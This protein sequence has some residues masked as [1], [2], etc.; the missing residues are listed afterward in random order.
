MMLKT[1]C[2]GAA[3][4][5]VILS[6]CSS[7]SSSD[8]KPRIASI[9][10]VAEP[11]ADNDQI[12]VAFVRNVVEASV[13]LAGNWTVES[14]IGTAFDLTGA[15]ID[16]DPVTYTA[17]V[18]LGAGTVGGPFGNNLQFGDSLSVE[19]TGV[20]GTNGAPLSA[21][22]Q[23]AVTG[24]D[25]P[26]RTL[27]VY[28]DGVT[29]T[30]T[31]R[32]SEAAREVLFANL[33]NGMPGDAGPR[34]RLTDADGTPGT[35][36]T[37]QVQLTGQPLDGDFV[38][39][40]DG[41]VSVDF[42]FDS[43]ASVVET[44]TLRQ[45]V[46][47]P[48]AADTATNLFNAVNSG[49]YTFDVTATLAVLDVNL[50][51]DATGVAGNVA[52]NGNGST[53][54]TVTGMTGGVDD[55]ATIEEPLGPG[56]GWSLDEEGVTVD[57]TPNVPNPATDTIEIY[58][59][60]DLA[61]NAAFPEAAFALEAEDVS[62]PALDT[63]SSTLNVVSGE[64]NDTI[65]ARFDSDMSATHIT[66]PGNYSAGALDLSGAD[67]A[68]D[69]SDTLT[70]TLPEGQDIQVG[71]SYN[72]T[73]VANMATPLTTAQGVPLAL[74]E[75]EAVTAT[76]DT[77]AIIQA[78]TSGYVGDLGNPSTAVVV[79]P[80]AVDVAGATA[81]ANYDILAANPTAIE[82]L[83]P[84]SMRLT[85]ASAPA[86]TDTLNIQPAAAT[87]RGGTPAAGV[88]SIVLGAADATAPTAT[89]S[90]TSVAGRGGDSI[91]I[92]FD[93][94]VRM[95]QALD[96]DSYAVTEDLQPVDLTGATLSYES[97]GDVVRIDL[98]AGTELTTGSTVAVTLTGV[99]DLSGN[100]LSAQPAG[101]ATAGDSTAPDFDGA[102]FVN[103]VI[104]NSGRTLDVLFDEDVD[105][106]FVE[107]P[108]NWSTDMLTVVSAVEL[109]APDIARVTVAASLAANELLQL[110]G[111]PDLAGNVSGAI[112]VD[113]LE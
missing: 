19:W 53:N 72:L 58:G 63:G 23:L 103:Y 24:D 26:P 89:L 44:P 16:Y 95:A 41:S 30:A 113:P 82:Q 60:F 22:A 112:S 94:P 84:R 56:Y 92:D 87:D 83:T 64:A 2:V 6:S 8:P 85:F 80:E 20:K 77:T 3:A 47:G 110:T 99:S 75:V 5:A 18:T 96:A 38:T 79:F 39:I 28:A 106:T 68:F 109:I 37:G 66:E 57:F 69:G 25:L 46:I 40:S 90:S 76:G 12:V 35:A 11:G 102:A 61:G 15:T 21:T 93:E 50:A 49:A 45:V 91:L 10:A 86:A 32:F 67:F 70:I 101:V 55:V 74:N 51:N 62:V 14:P 7:S 111:L 105:E 78:Q 100:V 17:T 9:E 33:Y 52:I 98:P 43:N 48:A 4:A 81:L 88:I 97:A 34:F 107:T 1:I 42:E 31:V 54:V 36:A 108:G 59:V 104:D 13:E 73:L 71:S 29:T 27:S 65:V